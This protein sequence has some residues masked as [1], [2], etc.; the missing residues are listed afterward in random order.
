M[1]DEGDS[2]V[3]FLSGDLSGWKELN[4]DKENN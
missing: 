1:N 3:I 4:T 2:S